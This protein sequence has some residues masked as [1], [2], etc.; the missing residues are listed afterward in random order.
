M[1]L[2]NLSTVCWRISSETRGD[3]DYRALSLRRNIWDCFS[4]QSH[5]WWTT[6]WRLI[7]DF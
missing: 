5:C 1:T 2:T 3:T 4:I 6:E 7:C